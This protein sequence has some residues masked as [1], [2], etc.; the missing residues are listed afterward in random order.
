MT[1]GEIA[2]EAV[3]RLNRR[4]NRINIFSAIFRMIVNSCMHI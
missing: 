4:I 3:R 2:E 1:P